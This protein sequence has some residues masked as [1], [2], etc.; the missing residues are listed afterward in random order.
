MIEQDSTRTRFNKNK[1]EQE[2]IEIFYEVQN[3]IP[4]TTMINKIEDRTR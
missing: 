4:P 1:I 3:N 2:D